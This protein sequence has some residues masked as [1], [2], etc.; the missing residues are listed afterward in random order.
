[1]FIRSKK[2]NRYSRCINYACKRFETND[3]EELIDS[4]QIKIINEINLNCTK[5][6]FCII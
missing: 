4:L 6:F 3:N 5:Q 1:M 2:F